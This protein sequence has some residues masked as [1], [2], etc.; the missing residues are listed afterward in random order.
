[1]H[2]WYNASL[3]QSLAYGSANIVSIE[4]IV[5][6]ILHTGIMTSK[7]RHQIQA[8]SSGWAMSITETTALEALAEA[9]AHN[10]ISTGHDRFLKVVA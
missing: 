1:M 3:T 5:Q 10:R 2:S 8:L 7:Q 6:T 4:S 9:L